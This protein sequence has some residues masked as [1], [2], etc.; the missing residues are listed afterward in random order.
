MRR[1]IYRTVQKRC[2]VSNPGVTNTAKG[3]AH[4]E[5]EIFAR[6]SWLDLDIDNYSAE[7]YGNLNIMYCGHDNGLFNNSCVIDAGDLIT[8]SCVCDYGQFSTPAPDTGDVI[9]WILI[10][11]VSIGCFF[12]V[13]CALFCALWMKK[14]SEMIE[15]EI[16]REKQKLKEVKEAKQDNKKY[17]EVKNS[18]EEDDEK[19]MEL[20]KNGTKQ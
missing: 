16:W 1:S 8:N 19:Q 12:F 6:N 11:A 15:Y 9:D 10:I 3:D 4:H 20:T 17:E 5:M 14:D 2:F 13:I 7:I 18:E